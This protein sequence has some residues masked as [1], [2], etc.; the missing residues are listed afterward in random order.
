MFKND[1]VFIYPVT[2]QYGNKSEFIKKRYFKIKDWN[3]AGL[4]RQSYIDTGTIVKIPS[5]AI[6]NKKPIGRLSNTDK[7]KLLEFLTK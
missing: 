1:F 6:A 2:T 5:S 3:Q 4:A 7:Q